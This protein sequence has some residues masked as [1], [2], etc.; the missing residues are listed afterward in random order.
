MYVGQQVFQRPL[1]VVIDSGL[2]AFH[3]F[4]LL[5]S[6]TPFVASRWTATIKFARL[7][8]AYERRIATYDHTEGILQGRSF[9]H[10]STLK[11]C[12]YIIRLKA[13][14]SNRAHLFY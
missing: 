14:S 8:L 6:K 10:I 4:T 2:S 9:R 7:K 3:N 12:K 5:G 11:S 1:S 13:N